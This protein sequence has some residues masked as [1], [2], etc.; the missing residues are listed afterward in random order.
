MGLENDL[1]KS[2]LLTGVAKRKLKATCLKVM[3]I[4]GAQLA[5]MFRKARWQLAQFL[6]I[7]WWRRY[8]KTKDKANYLAEKRAY[9]LRVLTELAYTPQDGQRVLDA[10]CG[11]AGIFILLHDRQRVT[12]LDPLLDQYAGQLPIFSRAAYPG[13][14]FINS[15]LEAANIESNTFEVVYCFNAINHV[16]DWAKGLDR[17]TKWTR[18]KGQLIL[19]SDVHRRAWLRTVFRLLP[20]DLL[21]PHQHLSSEYRTALVARGWHIE[22]E[23]LLRR[24][25]IFDYVAWVAQKHT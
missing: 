4:F 12:A 15:P 21:H 2:K 13:V 3:I 16:E 24:S 22:K 19:S 8:L 9:W 17:L 5:Y 11:P 1:G 10:G 7:R 6:E 18:Y 14:T 25:F 23:I 20:G